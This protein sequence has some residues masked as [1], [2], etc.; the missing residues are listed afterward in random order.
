MKIILRI[1]VILDGYYEVRNEDGEDRTMLLFHGTADGDFFHGEILPGGVDTQVQKKGELRR[2]SARYI[3]SGEDFNGNTCKIFIENNG[4]VG[5][6][7]KIRTCL[8]LFTDS[9]ALKFLEEEKLTG[10]VVQ[11]PGGPLEIIIGIET[12]TEK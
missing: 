7:G 8:Q 2:L 5:E 6:D 10:T 11:I 3:L 1:S 12:D 9:K 4:E